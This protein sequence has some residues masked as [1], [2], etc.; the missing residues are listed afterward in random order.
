M[1]LETRNVLYKAEL[2]LRPYTNS[3]TQV[4]FPEEII[5]YTTDK[6]NRLSSEILN[7]DD[8]T[9]VADF[10]FDDMYR[11]NIHYSFDITNFILDELS[12]GYFNQEN[13]LVVALPSETFKSSGQRLVLDARN[14]NDFRPLL[15]LYFIM[16]E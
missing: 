5:L 12:D 2:I 9:L 7:D 13:G 10:Y 4:D 15:K 11:E 1:E 8:E 6:Y 3:D 14:G 16:Y